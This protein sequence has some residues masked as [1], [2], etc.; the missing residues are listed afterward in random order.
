M[1][2]GWR[3]ELTIRR[4]RGHTSTSWRTA[5]WER[6]DACINAQILKY[7]DITICVQT[8]RQEG[9]Y[10]ED[11]YREAHLGEDHPFQD[12]EGKGAHLEVPSYQAAEMEG[13][14][15]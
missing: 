11:P 14:L 7:I 1:S 8:Y 12:R 6:R 4:E 5:R 15:R 10:Q 3:S 2:R 13:E 9:S